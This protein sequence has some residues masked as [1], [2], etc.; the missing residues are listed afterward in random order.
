MNELTCSR[1]HFLFEQ[2]RAAVASKYLSL[3]PEQQ[4]SVVRA[5]SVLQM[6]PGAF[7]YL[8]PQVSTNSSVWY[9]S[10]HVNLSLSRS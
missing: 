4:L 1:T 7:H 3:K 5:V 8:L 9:L 6:A 2:D 10:S